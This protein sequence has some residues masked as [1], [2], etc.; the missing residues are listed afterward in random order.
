MNDTSPWRWTVPLVLGAGLLIV[1]G[2]SGGDQIRRYSVEKP[3]PNDR[4]LAAIIPHAEQAWFF[5]LSGPNE[6]L[7]GLSSVFSDFIESVRIPAD[8]PT[9]ELP[10]GWTRTPGNQ[11]RFATILID[12]EDEPL[13]LSVTQLPKMPDDTQLLLQNIN[14]WRGQMQLSPI[15]EDRLPAESVQ[16]KLGPDSGLTATLINIAGNMPA[17]GGMNA[18]PFAGGSARPSGSQPMSTA[19]KRKIKYATP[20][21]WQAGQLVS[22]RGGISIARDA[23]FDVV[24]GSA[25]AEITVTQ[26]PA[27]PQSLQQNVSRWRQQVDL[28]GDAD[29]PEL[30]E[31]DVGG[32]GGV[33]MELIGPER[34]ILGVIALDSGLGWF[35]KLFG[36]RD[37]ALRERERFREFVES[38]EFQDGEEE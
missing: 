29:P 34:A 2:C 16:M 23:A 4:M 30:K 31:V 18:A 21:G 13:E 33:S 6:M 20:A 19:P 12:T 15:S 22:S 24:E 32:V 5:K 28:A 35:V 10:Q 3:V 26:M 9:W 1:G 27:S 8:E 11:A 17:G 7:R 14:R 25:R 37:L 36:D 38:I